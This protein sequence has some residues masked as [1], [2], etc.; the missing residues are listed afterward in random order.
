MKSIPFFR[1]MVVGLFLFSCS[2]ENTINDTKEKNN[3]QEI[4]T[5]VRVA[6]IGDSITAGTGLLNPMRDSYPA[7]LSRLLGKGWKVENFGYKG[8]TLLKQGSRPYWHTSAYARS[9]Q[10]TPDIVIIM[11][12][13]NDAKPNNWRK[14]QQFVL[15]YKALIEVYTQLSS[16]PIIYIAYP[17]PVY[18]TPAGITN[19]RIYDEVIP[20]ITEVASDNSIKIIDVYSAL[21]DKKELFPDTVHP[22][23][24]GAN[25]LAQTVYRMIY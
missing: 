12:G 16:K 4:A 13:T 17:P 6:C 20:K 2:Q 22:N 19:A 7:Q 9:L 1:A 3:T 23:A 14:K 5:P 24:Q 11:L 21:S 8:A 15:D 18:G 25:I 10:Y